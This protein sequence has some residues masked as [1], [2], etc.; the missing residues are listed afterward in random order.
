MQN[1]NQI[2][3]QILQAINQGKSSEDEIANFLKIEVDAVD[4]YLDLLKQSGCI[5]GI[6]GFDGHSSRQTHVSTSLTSK[7]KF[8]LNNPNILKVNQESSG[9]TINQS[10]NF[11]IG[12]MSGRDIKEGAKVAGVINEAEKPTLAEAAAEIQKLLKQLE[13]SNPSATVE[14]QQAFVNIAVSP[15]LKARFVSALQSGW[16][17]AMKELLDNPYVNVGIALLEGWQQAE[18]NRE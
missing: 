2:Q 4:Y 16:K 14:Q 6:K 1:D 18:S 9:I 12:Q 15:T 5:V 11:G 17:E 13:E 10:G 3:I 8:A 7:G